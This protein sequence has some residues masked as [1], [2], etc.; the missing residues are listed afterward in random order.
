MTG[1]ELNTGNAMGNNI[2]MNPTILRGGRQKYKDQ[3]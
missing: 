3:L 2:D 1:F